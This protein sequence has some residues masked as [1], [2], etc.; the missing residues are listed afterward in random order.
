MAVTGAR[1]AGPD[2]ELLDDVGIGEAHGVEQLRPSS[3]TSAP[4]R[5]LTANSLVATTRRVSGSISRAGSGSRSI[6]LDPQLLAALRFGARHDAVRVQP[7]ENR[8][9][10][11]GGHRAGEQGDGEHF[12]QHEQVTATAH[13]SPKRTAAAPRFDGRT[14]R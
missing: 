12:E 8:A 11:F 10:I 2:D 3:G 14:A 4:C 7:L 13:R 1:A 9:E 5:Y 6:R